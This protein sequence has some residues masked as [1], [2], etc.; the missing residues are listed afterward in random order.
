MDQNS[1]GA[2][3][4]QSG[5]NL[6]FFKL[7]D[8]NRLDFF[9]YRVMDNRNDSIGEKTLSKV[10]IQNKTNDKISKFL[11]FNLVAYDKATRFL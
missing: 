2:F 3:K 11:G 9:I 4:D 8:A 10:N 5:N 1:S 6:Y 7:E